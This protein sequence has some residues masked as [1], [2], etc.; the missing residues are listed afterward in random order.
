MWLLMSIAHLWLGNYAECDDCGRNAMAEFEPY[1]TGWYVA[2]GHVATACGSLSRSDAL[3]EL[4]EALAVEPPEPNVAREIAA[5]RLAVVMLRAGRRDQADALVHI[6]DDSPNAEETLLCAWREVVLSELASQSGDVSRYLAHTQAATEQF[7]FA[8]DVRNACLQ[9]HN[10]GDALMQLGAYQRAEHVFREVLDIAEPM[11]L[12]LVPGALANLG[13][14]LSRIGALDTAWEVESRALA[15]CAGQGY[16]RFEAVASLYLALILAMQR[17]VP[18]ATELAR[19]GVALAATSPPTLAQAHAVLA[20]MLLLGEEPTEALGEARAAMELL[21]RLGGVEEAESLIRLVFMTALA[22]C[23][24]MAAARQA[25]AAAR[26]RLLFRAD[27]IANPAW[28]RSFLGDVP[29]HA[30]TLELAAQ[31]LEDAAGAEAVGTAQVRHTLL[32]MGGVG[33]RPRREAPRPS[34]PK[35]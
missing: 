28:R 18:A 29:E 35:A 33:A 30:S 22:R 21:E 32:G 16:R 13:F 19:N 25:A 8:G 9:R 31:W 24:D 20:A 6:V 23:G 27:R 7:T 10:V 11:R 3:T 5:C 17:D 14:T 26:E 12:N 34:G 1:T 4:A 15:L 2:L